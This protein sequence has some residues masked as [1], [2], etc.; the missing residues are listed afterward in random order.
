MNVNPRNCGRFGWLIEEVKRV[1]RE[2][3]KCP[4]GAATPDLGRARKYRG[5]Y[6]HE[7]A[8]VIATLE[9]V[10]EP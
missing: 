5:P 6:Y 2:G 7:N 3:V 10:T 1:K 8:S 9:T 4:G